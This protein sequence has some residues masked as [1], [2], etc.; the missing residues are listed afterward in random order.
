MLPGNPPRRVLSARPGGLV[1]P[2]AEPL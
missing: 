2:D 1:D